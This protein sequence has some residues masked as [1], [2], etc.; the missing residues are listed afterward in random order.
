M[1]KIETEPT[2]HRGL[3]PAGIAFAAALITGIGALILLPVGCGP[4]P[5]EDVSGDVEDALDDFYET[6]AEA[7]LDDLQDLIGGDLADEIEEREE[8]GTL[9][10]FWARYR[11]AEA[12]VEEIEVDGDEAEAT[13]ILT[14]GGR[15]FEQEVELELEDDEWLVLELGELEIY[16][17][18]DEE[19]E[20]EQQAGR[21]ERAEIPT[22]GLVPVGGA[23]EQQARNT[24]ERFFAAVRLTD[25]DRVEGLLTGTALAEFQEWRQ[26]VQENPEEFESFRQQSSQTSF[27]I[28]SVALD[29]QGRSVTVNFRASYADGNEWDQAMVLQPTDG[30]WRIADMGVVSAPEPE[31][32]EANCSDAQQISLG[33]VVGGN[34]RGTAVEYYRFAISRAATYV[35]YTSGSVDTVGTLLDSDCQQL[36]SDDDSGDN[37]NFRIQR[38]LAPGTYYVSVRGYS[39]GSTGP[40]TLTVEELSGESAAAGGGDCAGARQTLDINREVSGNLGGA[41][42]EIYYRVEIARAGTYCFET[43][44]QLDVVGRL[45][46]GNCNE[47]ANNDDGGEGFNFRI[48]QFLQPG[49]Y[50]VAV[51]A[52]SGGAS[53]TFSLSFS[54]I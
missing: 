30:E 26:R 45:F 25:L 41:S 24:A 6:A 40:Y 34:A 29:E 53:G 49:T 19:G 23:A 14:V 43:S 12:E 51:R 9:E 50:Y 7:D 17:E 22:P 32:A 35:V 42:Q 47:L 20:E 52:Y 44:G 11:G 18:E 4:A 48:E 46:D 38:G 3:Q 54:E 16:V 37:A 28:V 39:S 10:E 2:R 13:V 31:E 5:T 36:D 33:Q 21:E 15:Q 8:N 27:S 1:R